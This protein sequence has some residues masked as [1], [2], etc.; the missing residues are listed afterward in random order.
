MIRVNGKGFDAAQYDAE[1]SDYAAWYRRTY[2]PKHS[3]KDKV[4]NMY[5]H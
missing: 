3:P 5:T 4:P 1:W 2:P